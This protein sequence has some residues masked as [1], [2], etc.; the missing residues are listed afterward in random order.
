[1]AG[2]RGLGR[3][4]TGRDRRA[5]CAVR[6]SGRPR[7]QRDDTQVDQTGLIISLVALAPCR[8]CQL[9]AADAAAPPLP[10]LPRCPRPCSVCLHPAA[11]ASECRLH[12]PDC[13]ASNRCASATVSAIG[14]QQQAAGAAGGLTSG[15]SWPPALTARV[16]MSGLLQPRWS[17]SWTRR[18]TSAWSWCALKAR[19]GR[20]TAVA[21]AQSPSLPR[22]PNCGAAS[23]ASLI[24][25]TSMNSSVPIVWASPQRKEGSATSLRVQFEKLQHSA[26]QS[27]KCSAAPCSAALFAQRGQQNEAQ[28]PCSV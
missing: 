1:M 2:P 14:Q 13:I 7:N 28:C 23:K 24:V 3:A 15:P 27:A 4:L 16:V 20:A 11:A 10:L 17:T 19:A 18:Q 21:A 9:S 6:F 12:V 22:E 8:T 5:G 25:I 26:R